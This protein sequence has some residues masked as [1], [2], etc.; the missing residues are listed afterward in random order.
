MAELIT[1]PSVVADATEAVLERWLVEVGD[2]VIAGTPLAELETEKATVEY[3]AEVGGVVSRLLVTAGS[4][5]DIGDPIALLTG[6]DE[7]H[8]DAEA[9]LADTNRM[10]ADPE[11]STDENGAS[12]PK[13][14]SAPPKESE[15]KSAD[16]NGGNGSRRFASPL[17][18]RMAREHNIDVSHVTGTGPSGRLLRRDIEAALDDTAPPH[19]ESSAA[20]QTE[21]L[22]TALEKTEDIKYRDEPVSGM[23]RAI[24]RR[25]TE[26]KTATPHF[27]LS[28]DIRMDSLFDLRRQINS[29]LEA[30]GDR[31]TV[32]DML[33]KALG[34]ALEDVPNANAIWQGE[35]IR[36]FTSVDVA[37]AMATSK[38]LLTPVVHDVT[39]RSLGVLAK[40]TS[41]LKER[42]AQGQIRQQE[43]EGGSFSISNLGMYG[44][45]EFSAIINP[46]HAGIVAIGATEERPV[47]EE[48]ELAVGNVMTATLSAD[49]RVIDGVVGA[50]LM[51]SFTRHLEN[52]LS[53]LL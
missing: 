47:V 29:S 19:V 51:D 43:L 3:E 28:V 6:P 44:T 7:D 23:R 42:A 5:V 45:K 10:H 38:G 50:E 20:P 41:T 37:V 16:A 33:V 15:Q 48:G 26:S 30:S 34:A 46:P 39:D 36:Q 27:Y 25:L 14:S 32:N 31:I 52:P 12:S 4:T 13:S 40:I 8:S 21:A 53:I 18:R 35:T 9:L 22:D 1:M 49:H 24:A 17:A 11:R 2:E